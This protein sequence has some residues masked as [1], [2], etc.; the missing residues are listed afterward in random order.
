MMDNAYS[1]KYRTF[2]Q[3]FEDVSIDFKN[4][5]LEGLVEPQTLIKIARK[6]NYDLGLRI[7]RTR[8]AILEV[9]HGK[10]RLP[11]DFHILNFASVCGEYTITE[12]LPQGTHVEERIIAPKYVPE[13][14]QPEICDIKKPEPCNVCDPCTNVNINQCGNEYELVQKIHSHTRT[15]K[16]KYPLHITGLDYAKCD[17]C[18]NNQFQG[19]PNEARIENGFLKTNFKHGKVYINYEGDLIDDDGN[20]LVPDHEMINEFYEYALKKRILENLIMNDEQVGEKYNVIAAEFRVAR[21]HA[22]T[23]VNTPNFKELKKLWETNRKAQYHKYY[24]MFRSYFPFSYKK[25]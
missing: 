5:T 21:N 20:L 11:D 9:E 1:L 19:G 23:I 18:L 8:Q 10:V 12:E 25:Y 2:D 24:D 15:Y 16:F 13:P 14:G 3:L 4:Y 7:Y 17:G 22:L 6:C